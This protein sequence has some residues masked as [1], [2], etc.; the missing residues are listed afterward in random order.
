M[1][2]RVLGRVSTNSH[3]AFG[4]R[5][6]PAAQNS[7]VSCSS[8]RTGSCRSQGAAPCETRRCTH[9]RSSPT[10][11]EDRSR[12]TRAA[13]CSS[14]ARACD[15]TRAARLK[16]GPVS[17]FRRLCGSQRAGMGG[18]GRSLSCTA[19]LRRSRAASASLLSR[20]R[21]AFS[22]RIVHGPEGRVLICKVLE[23]VYVLTVH[24][25]LDSR[26]LPQDVVPTHGINCVRSFNV[27]QI[28]PNVSALPKGE[29]RHEEVV[30]GTVWLA[31]VL[32]REGIDAALAHACVEQ[33]ARRQLIRLHV[34][35]NKG[36]EVL[37]RL[38]VKAVLP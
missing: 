12:W 30:V 26:R 6:R 19:T 2:L 22:C 38:L 5:R 1:P 20:H 31:T 17:G 10:P 24:E 29:A 11:L 23:H 13:P 32:Q 3:Q 21:P 15:R 18:A 8:A 16:P 34:S 4:S 37:T 28:V 27:G 14:R 9:T 36:V 33:P 35:T 25:Q 7:S